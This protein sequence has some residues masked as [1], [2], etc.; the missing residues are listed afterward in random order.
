MIFTKLDTK[1][2][3]LICNDI[4]LHIHLKEFEK[5][6]NDLVKYDFTII[7]KYNEHDFMRIRKN[8]YEKII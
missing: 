5:I 4:S 7:D 3:R 1:E 2:I 8:I 6:N